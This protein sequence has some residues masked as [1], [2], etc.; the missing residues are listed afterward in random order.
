MTATEVRAT[1]NE[2]EA[3]LGGVYTTL[4]AEFQTPLVY[5]ML[6][7]L[8]PKVLEVTTPSITTGISA[9]SR[10]RDFQNLNT[11]LQ[12]LAQLGPEVLMKY[13]NIPGYLTKVAASLGMDPTDLVK[14]PE[15]IKQEEQQALMQQQAMMASQAAAN[16]MEAQMKGQQGQ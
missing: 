16:G 13:M 2:L 11:M 1:V 14:T 7:E 10:E 4:A 12:A 8:N 9:I 15:Q 6:N 5:L 3:A